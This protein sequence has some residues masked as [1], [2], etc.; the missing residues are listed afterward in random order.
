VKNLEKPYLFITKK[1]YADKLQ[2]NQKNFTEFNELMQKDKIIEDINEKHR[3]E[4][5]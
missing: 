1:Q 2:A 3:F 5:F 4:S